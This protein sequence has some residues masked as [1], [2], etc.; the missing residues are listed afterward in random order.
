MYIFVAIIDNIKYISNCVFR[1]ENFQVLNVENNELEYFTKWINYLFDNKKQ[2]IEYI[3]Q[4]NYINPNFKFDIIIDEDKKL[5][6]VKNN[7]KPFNDFFNKIEIKLKPFFDDEECYPTYLYKDIHKY[8]QKILKKYNNRI[9]NSYKCHPIIRKYLHH[10]KIYNDIV[11]MYPDDYKEDIYGPDYLLKNNI[12][13][14]KESRHECPIDGELLEIN[15]RY[16]DSDDFDDFDELDNLD[17]QNI[18]KKYNSEM[19]FYYLDLDEKTKYKEVDEKTK[20]LYKNTVKELKCFY[21]NIDKIPSPFVYVKK[22]NEDATKQMKYYNDLIIKTNDKNKEL[23]KVYQ[24][25][26][27]TQC[28]RKFKFTGNNFIGM[29]NNLEAIDFKISERNYFVM[30]EYCRNSVDEDDFYREVK[31]FIK[32]NYGWLYYHNVEHFNHHTGFTTTQLE[33]EN[34]NEILH[35]CFYKY[36]CTVIDR[37]ILYTSCVSEKS[38][39]V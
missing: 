6:L 18:D 23:L 27:I 37:G 12:E 5:V 20:Q 9:D 22:I 26:Y 11:P 13:Y 14:F 15:N 33:M 16:D 34:M 32:F 36:M 38:G 39:R 7:N 29:N 4:L 24:L 19:I 10:Y 17:N 25:A 2:S 28:C 31:Y 3:G 21:K 35:P 1:K 30:N 8:C